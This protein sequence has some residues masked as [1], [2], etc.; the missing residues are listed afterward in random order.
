MMHIYVTELTLTQVQSFLTQ[1]YNFHDQ[2]HYIIPLSFLTLCL[3]WSSYEAVFRRGR[4]FC[5]LSC[6]L[7]QWPGS[8]EP[9][10]RL[11]W[12]GH[13]EQNCQIHDNLRVGKQKVK[14]RKPLLSWYSARSSTSNF[15]NYSTGA[16]IINKPIAYLR[17]GMGQQ[18][19][20]KISIDE[21]TCPCLNFNGG[22]DLDK[23]GFRHGCDN[24]F[25]DGHSEW[26][27]ESSSEVSFKSVQNYFLTDK[28]FDTKLI[29]C[30]GHYIRNA[31]FTDEMTILI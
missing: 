5:W 25:V 14:Q 10:C 21:I 15:V 30:Y 12:T 16:S 7:Q 29:K 28:Y 1:D 20:K 3:Y 18:S 23:H 8:E 31:M 6:F 22:L 27:F 11:L 26:N 24:I 17:W 19:Y 2:Q 4:L 13:H 9:H